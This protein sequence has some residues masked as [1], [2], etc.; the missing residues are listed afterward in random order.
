MANDIAEAIGD[1]VQQILSLR[2]ARNAEMLERWCAG[3][4]LT[5]LAVRFSLTRQRVQQIVSR[6]ATPE[7]WAARA[8]KAGRPKRSA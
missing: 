5:A 3:E 2:A 8:P 7:Q 1:S 6:D 4:T